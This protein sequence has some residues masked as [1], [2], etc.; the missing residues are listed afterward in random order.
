[1]LFVVCFTHCSTHPPV[2]FADY[3]CTHLRNFTIAYFCGIGQV[4]EMVLQLNNI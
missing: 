4:G 1:M 2:S 3:L